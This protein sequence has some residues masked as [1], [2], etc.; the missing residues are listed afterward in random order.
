ML[1]R[2]ITQRMLMV[3]REKNCF[4]Q[5]VLV[6]LKMYLRKYQKDIADSMEPMEKLI[7]SKELDPEIMDAFNASKALLFN[8][9]ELYRRYI[10]FAY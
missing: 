2:Y 3:L 1:T 9:S 4:Y 8:R 7:F 10:Q 5:P 6:H